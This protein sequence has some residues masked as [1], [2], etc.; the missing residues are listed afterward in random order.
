MS[1]ALAP[2]GAPAGPSVLGDQTVIS[3]GRAVRRSDG[4][5]AG[6]STLLDGCLRHAREWLPWL[7]TAEVVRMATQTPA[8]A[9]GLRR[10][11]RVAVG[12]DA[13]LVVLDEELRVRLTLVAGEV[14]AEVA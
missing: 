6:S 12:A 3:D 14:V 5:L 8:D 1:D 2:A 9:L 4:I 13:D 11:G 10:K 7:S